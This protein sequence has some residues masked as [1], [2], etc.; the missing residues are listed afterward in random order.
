M[1]M[2]RNSGRANGRPRKADPTKAKE[3]FIAQQPCDGTEFLTSRTPFGMTVLVCCRGID[4]K[5]SVA[6][7]IVGHGGLVGA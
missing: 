4:I 2:L 1:P 7:K 3:K 6:R 5:R